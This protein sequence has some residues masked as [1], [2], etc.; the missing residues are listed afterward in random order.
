MD[1]QMPPKDSSFRRHVQVDFCL[2]KYSIT[3]SHLLEESK[4]PQGL[5]CPVIQQVERSTAPHQSVSL[6]YKIP[7]CLQAQKTHAT[8][9]KHL[10][11][12]KKWSR[13]SCSNAFIFS[14]PQKL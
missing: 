9:W 2:L 10:Y 8:C 7:A 3:Q 4:R 12:P 11:K 5:R 13:I 6:P 14:F 1:E